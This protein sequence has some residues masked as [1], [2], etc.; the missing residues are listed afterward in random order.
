MILSTEELNFDNSRRAV[1]LKL[2]RDAANNS[3]LA[4]ADVPQP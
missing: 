2:G 3:F 4:A 1:V